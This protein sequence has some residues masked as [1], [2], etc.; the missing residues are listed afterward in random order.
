MTNSS[1]ALFPQGA[2][3]SFSQNTAVRRSAANA[4]SRGQFLEAKD[5]ARLLSAF[6]GQH[7]IG[8]SGR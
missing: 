3:V 5:F 7:Q 6:A 4:L 8:I 1:R 2:D